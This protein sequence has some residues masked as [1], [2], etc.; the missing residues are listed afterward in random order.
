M[1]WNRILGHEDAIAQ[2]RQAYVRGRLAHAYMFVGPEGIGKKLVAR[3]VAKA[4]LCERPS[5]AFTACDVC[6]ACQQLEAGTHPDFAIRG[7]L[8]DKLELTLEVIRSLCHELGQKPLRGARKI[9][10]LDDADFFNEEAANS[11]LKNLE[12]PPQ[13]S[14]LILIATSTDRQL[15]TIL[16]RCQV[17]RF[18]ALSEDHL[19]AILLQ[20]ELA[21]PALLTQILRMANGSASLALAMNDPDLWEL[22]LGI[23]R[24]LAQT[25]PDSLTLG[26]KWI[27]YVEAAGKE[28]VAQRERTA[29]VLIVIVELLRSALRHSFGSQELGNE[30]ESR[31]LAVIGNLLGPQGIADL[32]EVCITGFVN[33]D[34]RLQGVL[35]MEQVTDRLCLR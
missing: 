31:Q 12:E 3:E 15:A 9:T 35:L 33:I 19:R 26:Q 32:L 11:F 8:E 18:R 2:L 28:S 24:E 5:E 7:R 30:E 16:S 13:G 22:R 29:L 4:L 17:V 25:R 20:Y 1:S 10:V 6:P 23:L 14:L 21:D 27:Q 34:R